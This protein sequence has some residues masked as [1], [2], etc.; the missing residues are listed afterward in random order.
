M[1]HALSTIRTIRIRH[2][3]RP[4]AGLAA[5]VMALLAGAAQATSP[6]SI[7]CPAEQF[8]SGNM[9][10]NPG[11][12]IPNPDVPV[13]KT[14]CWNAQSGSIDSAAK[15][16]TIHS[17]NDRAEVCSTLVKSKAPGSKG[18]LMMKF[19]A[20]S[21]EGGI[22]QLVPGAAGKTYMFSAWV[23]VSK[24]RVALQPNGGGIGPIS[25]SSKIGEWE[26]LRV[27]TDSIGITDSM[28][29]YNQTGDGGVFYVDGV[30]LRE[31]VPGN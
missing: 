1:F 2:F 13:G 4:T 26:Q 18:G 27:C 29:I 9:A 6:A 23:K 5:A 3:A 10:D 7:Y 17:S 21:N 19:E 30:E 16:W 28:V 24:G 11:F 20:G 14:T 31:T 25:W 12:E 15:N 8:L 22:F